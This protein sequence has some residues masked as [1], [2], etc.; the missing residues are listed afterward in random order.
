[1]YFFWKDR[2]VSLYA[3]RIDLSVSDCAVVHGTRDWGQAAFDVGGTFADFGC[4]DVFNRFCGRYAGGCDVSQPVQRKPYQGEAVDF[5]RTE[6]FKSG[7]NDR[8]QSEKTSFSG[9]GLSL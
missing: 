1:M 4:S 2:V 9:A 3:R 8:R 7:R 6:C 5:Y